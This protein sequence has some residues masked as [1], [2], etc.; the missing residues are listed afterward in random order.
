[1]PLPLFYAKHYAAALPRKSWQ[2]YFDGSCLCT[3]LTRDLNFSGSFLYIAFID[4]LRNNCSNSLAKWSSGRRA[5]WEIPAHIPEV[6]QKPF[7]FSYSYKRNGFGIMHGTWT[8][9]SWQCFISP[10][11]KRTQFAE[12][13]NHC[14]RTLSLSLPSRSLLSSYLDKLSDSWYGHSWPSHHQLFGKLVSTTSSTTSTQYVLEQ[15]ASPQP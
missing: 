14:K 3:G 5:G 13:Q 1:M 4:K 9:T 15:W 8:V 7:Q 10:V 2:P 11:N 12:N 6:I